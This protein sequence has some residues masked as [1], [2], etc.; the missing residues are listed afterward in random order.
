[1]LSYCIMFC[2][3]LIFCMLLSY[4]CDKLAELIIN[5]TCINGFTPMYVH[6]IIM[7]QK[8]YNNY[9]TAYS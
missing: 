8:M 7:S 1:M 3:T 6:D 2:I 5:V 9:T 4:Q